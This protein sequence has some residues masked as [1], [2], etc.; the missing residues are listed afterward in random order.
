MMYS[1]SP[2]PLPPIIPVIGPNVLDLTPFQRE[3]EVAFRAGADSRR[4]NLSR[5]R[6]WSSWWLS[7]HPGLADRT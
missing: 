5:E 7:A 2:C 4:E 6:A 3:S 1:H